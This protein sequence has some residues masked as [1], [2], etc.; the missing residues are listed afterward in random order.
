MCIRDWRGTVTAD[1][2]QAVQSAK[3]GQVQ[4]RVEKQGIIHGGIGKASF[5]EAALVENATAFIG[6]V[7]RAKPSGVKG[8]Y[9]KKAVKLKRRRG[10]QLDVDPTNASTARKQLGI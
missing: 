2:G 5:A 7:V 3:A 9:V 6:A 1:V 4:F 10:R 8:T